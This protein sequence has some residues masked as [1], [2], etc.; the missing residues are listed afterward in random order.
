MPALYDIAWSIIYP[1]SLVGAFF[2]GRALWRRY[3]PR[4]RAGERITR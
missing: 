4:A 1:A 2:L 3:R